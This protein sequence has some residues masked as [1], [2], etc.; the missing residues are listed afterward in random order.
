MDILIKLLMFVLSLFMIV[1]V[2]L[3]RGRG[4][5][6]A[7]ALGG[8]GGQS[9]FGTKAGDFFTKITSVLAIIWILLCV[10][11]VTWYG[12]ESDA[13]VEDL[14]GAGTEAAAPADGVSQ[15]PKSGP[16]GAG[17]APAADSKAKSSGD[18]VTAEREEPAAGS[19][20]GTADGGKSA[21]AAPGGG[22]PGDTNQE[23]G[24]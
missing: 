24:N 9:A 6:L 4:G 5:G 22:R 23:H 7:G 1:L 17:G 11:A 12:R 19:K 21:P 18:G 2:L 20:A 16:E 10:V 14:G 8:M 13:F 15:R 3:Q